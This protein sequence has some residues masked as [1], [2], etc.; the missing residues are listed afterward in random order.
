MKTNPH[1]KKA[2]TR[3]SRASARASNK[4]GRAAARGKEWTN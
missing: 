2:G 4:T 3:A 1:T